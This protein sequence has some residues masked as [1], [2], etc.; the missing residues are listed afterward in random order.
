MR[1]KRVLNQFIERDLLAV[2]INLREV[3]IVGELR[4]FEID[5][6]LSRLSSSE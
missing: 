5:L 2:H 1:V 4:L 3:L 6:E